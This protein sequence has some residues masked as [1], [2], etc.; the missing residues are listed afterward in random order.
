MLIIGIAGGTA[1]GKTTI[2]AQLV[3]AFANDEITV[4]SQDDYYKET[5][6]LS[7]EERIAINFDHPSA[8]D[9]ELLTQHLIS[10]QQGNTIE[11]PVYSFIT[12]NRT[13]ETVAIKSSRILI[14]EGILLLSQPQLRNLIDLK[15][16]IDVDADERLIRRLKRDMNTRGRSME[17]VLD[18]YLQTIKPMHERYI[19]PTKKFAD[20]IISNPDSISQ[21]VTILKASIQKHLD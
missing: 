21:A 4:I 11:R 18:Q 15:I 16:F 9:F 2:I 20:L 13:T 3:T 1:C 17:Q 5:N 10:L 6:H 12:H 8:I 7:T 19:A 14:I